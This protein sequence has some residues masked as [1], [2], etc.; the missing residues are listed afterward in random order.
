MKWLLVRSFMTCFLTGAGWLFCA[1]ATV[2]SAG[3]T[4]PGYWLEAGVE[5]RSGNSRDP[6]SYNEAR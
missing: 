3:S 5:P 6:S 4:G 1:P 2:A